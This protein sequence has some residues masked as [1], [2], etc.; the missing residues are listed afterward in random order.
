LT[1]STG[2][3]GWPENNK[4]KHWSF[5]P[6][7]SDLAKAG[8]AKYSN[9]TNKSRRYERQFFPFSVFAYFAWFAVKN[10]GLLLQYCAS[11]ATPFRRRA[12][13]A[14]ALAKAG[15]KCVS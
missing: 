13:R 4:A 12:C 2:S 8:T 5:V 15:P 10:S 6:R 14:V 1:G 11:R 3:T 9:Q 7:R